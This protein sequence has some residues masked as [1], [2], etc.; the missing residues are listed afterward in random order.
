VGE[1]RNYSREN[2]KGWKKASSWD[3][4]QEAEGI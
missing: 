3:G 2:I 1:K 4:K